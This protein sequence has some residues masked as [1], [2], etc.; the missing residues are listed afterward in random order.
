M[1]L[2][3]PDGSS[4]IENVRTVT[5]ELARFSESLAARERWLV[6]NKMDLVAPGDR[7]ALGDTLVR[8]LGWDG[9]VYMLSAVS[10]E[11]CDVLCADIMSRL[12][13]LD[14]TDDD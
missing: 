9:P 12:E 4:P 1:D 3:P 7:K 10:G 2:V 5:D 11:G 14:D 13:A 6:L 8:E